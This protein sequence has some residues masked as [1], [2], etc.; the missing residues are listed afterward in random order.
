MTAPT[1]TGPTNAQEVAP[2][3][4][5]VYIDPVSDERFPSV[6]TIIGATSAKHGIAP[7]SSKLAAEFAI[8]NEIAWKAVLEAAGRDAAIE[9]IAKASDR[10][11]DAAG[12]RGSFVH[13]VIES[14][15]LDKPLPLITG[16]VEAAMLD[17]FLAWCA[18][19][20]VEF[21]MSE[22]TVANRTLGYAGTLDGGAILHACHDQRALI[23]AKTGKSLWPA[24]VVPQLAAYRGAEEVWLP[25]GGK[26]AMP[27]VDLV[28][29]LHLRA[30][31]YDFTEL[32]GDDDAWAD[33]TCKVASYYAARKIAGRKS[34]V[35]RV[36]RDND[37]WYVGDFPSLNRYAAPLAACGLTTLEQ[38]VMFTPT[39]LQRLE[40]IGPKAVEALLAAISSVGL[41]PT[42]QKVSA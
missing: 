8:D 25:L 16:D 1:K 18:D 3:G 21:F 6:T 22:L 31:G 13:D 30:D 23:D 32:R 29:A 42:A 20:E 24:E 15:V 28:A 10:Y 17:Q 40:G 35:G 7:W 9:L 11:R 19:Y 41:A 27:E 39:D 14:L 37:P 36:R 5:R 34:I 4:G 38:V 26:D 2:V 12:V 33:W